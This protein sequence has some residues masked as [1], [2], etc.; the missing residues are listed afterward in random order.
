MQLLRKEK[1][2]VIST[3]LL[4]LYNFSNTKEID[5]DLGTCS[6]WIIL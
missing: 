3:I 1:F 2:L 4:K 5:H 6:F